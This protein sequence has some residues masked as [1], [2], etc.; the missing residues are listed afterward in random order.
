MIN[1]KKAINGIMSCHQAMLTHCTFINKVGSCYL[2][3]H[4]QEA[5]AIGYFAPPLESLK[6]LAQLNFEYE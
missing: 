1:M 3:R 6:H 2:G 5:R 4:P